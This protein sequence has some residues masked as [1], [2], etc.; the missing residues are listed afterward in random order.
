MIH[1][2]RWARRKEARPAELLAAALKL[3]VEKG[4]AATR[5][6]DVAGA[7]GV[8]KGTL[9]LYYASKEDLFKAVVRAGL[10]P[11]LERGEQM[12]AQATGSS[13][14]LLTDLLLGWWEV[15]GA[16]DLGG[17]PKLMMSEAR[18][19]PEIAQFYHQEVVQRG[20]RLIR[21]ALE[22]GV[23]SGEFR[24]VDPECTTHLVLSPLIYQLIWRHSYGAC[25]VADLDPT[26][27]IRLHLDLL[28]HGLGASVPPHGSPA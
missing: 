19:F 16:G 27:F 14:Q 13:S 21:G 1:C 18:N 24:L 22:R 15:V 8:S 28:R 25:G 11:T 6:E 12:L 5:L 3:F 23:A 2:P 17:L 10:V 20:Q 4:F 26:A 7:A 9:Y